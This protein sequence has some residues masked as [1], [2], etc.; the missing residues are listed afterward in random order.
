MITRNGRERLVVLSVEE[1]DRLM[2]RDRVVLKAE[3]LSDAELAA[4]T[5]FGM[6]PRHDHLNA[7]LG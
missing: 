4:I 2:N 5:E 6:D 7:E 3:E 1:Y